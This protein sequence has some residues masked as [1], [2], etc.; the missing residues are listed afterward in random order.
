MSIPSQVADR[1][2]HG[3][4]PSLW[5]FVALAKPRITALVVTTTAGGVWLAPSHIDRRVSALAIAGVSLIVAGANALNMYIER[6][7]DARMKRTC[8][9]PLP[10]GRMAPSVAL[11]FGV[12]LSMAA[13]A[14]LAFGV[15]LTT[16]ILAGL[17][18]FTY[19]LAYTPLKQRSH[20]AVYVGAIAGAMPPLLGWTAVTGTVTAGAVLLFCVL[21]FW[22]IPHFLAIALF[23]GDE[24]ARAGLK[25]MPNCVGLLATKHA[26]VRHATALLFVNLLFVPMGILQR[27]YGMIAIV[28][29]VS[30]VSWA[31]YGMRPASETR[32]ARSLFFASLGYLVVLFGLFVLQGIT[33]S[34]PTGRP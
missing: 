20:W 8:N 13:I 9:R 23:R 22:Q 12:A 32:W 2:D 21:Y 24:Y 27:H 29:G 34:M 4:L 28:L 14:I 6:D 5:D 31:V 26:I 1:V 19:V 16:A 18:H 17:A 33:G 11:W 30:F 10:A 25:V 3:T 7:V 15:N